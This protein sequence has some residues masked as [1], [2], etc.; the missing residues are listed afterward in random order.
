MKFTLIF[1]ATAL[2]LTSAFYGLILA[3]DPYNKFGYNL[4][5]FETKAVDFA[6]VNK[7]NQIEHGKKD[8]TAFIMGSSSAHRYE[9][10]ALNELTGLVSYNYSTQSA[11]PE[12]FIAMTRHIFTKYKPKLFVISFDF[13]V[14]NKHFKTDDMFYAS[15]L[16]NYLNE[17]PAE[18]LEQDLFNNS[19][20]TLDAIADSFKVIFVNLFG[21]A[22]HA[23]LEDG[24]HVVEPAADKLV[25]NQFPYSLDYEFD[26]QR[27]EYLKT[28]KRLCDERGVR[29]VAL[30]APVSVEHLNRIE[31]D[32]FL[33]QRHK[34]FKLILRD[35]FGELWDFHTPEIEAY[36]STRYFQD[37]NHPTH[38]FSNMILEMIFKYQIPALSE[39]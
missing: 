39:K 1:S 28:I 29:I 38:E 8:Y 35:V 16:K 3:V 26:E 25:I 18:E 23:Y 27:I 33:N 10:K 19:Y 5:N 37:S 7:F 21:E 6:R 36:S 22:R 13:E 20:L 9:T 34:E 14:L 32:P 17:V 2:I 11:T 31:A 24:D 15:P 12:D 4:F 30:T